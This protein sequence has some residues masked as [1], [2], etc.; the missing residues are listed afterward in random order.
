MLIH[1]NLMSEEDND[2]RGRHH[3][4]GQFVRKL[5]EADRMLG[6]YSPMVEA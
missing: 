1:D 3:A 6:D 5:R 2:M 4:S